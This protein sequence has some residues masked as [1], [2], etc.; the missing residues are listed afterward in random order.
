MRSMVEGASDSRTRLAEKLKKERAGRSSRQ[1]LCLRIA[2][3]PSTAL[4]AVPLVTVLAK[5]DRLDA[6]VL[7]LFAVMMRPSARMPAPQTMAELAELV[8]ARASAVEAQSALKNQLGTAASKFL[9]RQL[10]RRIVRAGKD[11]AALDGEIFRRIQADDALA[12]RYAIL[13]SIPSFGFA[14]AATLIACLAEIGSMTAKQVGM[15]AGLA[16][17]ADQSGEREGTRVIWG[18]RPAVRRVLY[19][20]ALSAARF[21]TDM[22]TFYQRLRASGKPPK[23][24]LVAIARKLAVLANTLIHENRTWELRPPLHADPNT[25]APPLSRGRM[26]FKIQVAPAL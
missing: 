18:G 17:I 4:C 3:A 10:E 13:T 15:L 14:I 24:A 22:K 9:K 2:E 12:R 19:L 26:I 8:V 21:N 20:A 5:T 23:V 1:G 7:A 16:P 11:I 6:R 25:D